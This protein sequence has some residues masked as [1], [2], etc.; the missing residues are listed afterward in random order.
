MNSMTTYSADH[1]IRWQY[2]GKWCLYFLGAALLA[3]AALRAFPEVDFYVSDLF[4]SQSPCDGAS[5][6]RRC[7]AF[8]MDE[9][10][11]W[12]TI[13][14][15]G[16][17]L[18]RWLILAV[19]AYLIWITTLVPNKKLSDL[20]NPV[21]I[22]LAAFVGPALITNFILKEFWGRPRPLTN[23]MFG[24]DFP[25]IPPGDISDLC[26]TNCSFVSGEASAGF[27]MLVFLLFVKGRKRF[28]LAIFLSLLAIF[29]AG[30]RVAF[31][32]H[33]FSDV[34]M[35]G[36]IVG[37][38]IF[39]VLWLIETPF[40]RKWMVNWLNFSNRHVFGKK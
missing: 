17:R 33:Y 12:N 27:W 7:G 21:I 3:L 23:L 15:I 39:F 36:F 8:E 16:L 26:A 1:Q 40:V 18:P 20:E 28:G 14:M 32:R 25:Y 37:F 30:L 35:S 5:P 22:L 4:F 6:D 31:G 13:R 9:D 24:G 29:I 10:S 38:S 34:V 2:A 11:F 19:L